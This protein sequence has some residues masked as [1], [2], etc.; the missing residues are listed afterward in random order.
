MADINNQY[1]APDPQPGPHRLLS[2][3]SWPG[4][5]RPYAGWGVA[6]GLFEEFSQPLRPPSRSPSTLIRSSLTGALRHLSLYGVKMCIPGIPILVG[7]LARSCTHLTFYF[8]VGPPFPRK[9]ASPSPGSFSP[10]RAWISSPN[11]TFHEQLTVAKGTSQALVSLCLN[12]AT[13]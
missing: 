8:P 6:P 3:H 10:E 9:T 1:R 4:E 12:S 5:Q 2:S 7:R 13:I 11:S